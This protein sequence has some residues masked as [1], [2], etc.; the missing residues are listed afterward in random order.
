M[1]YRTISPPRSNSS[2]NYW[3]SIGYSGLAKAQGSNASCL[4]L[5]P[6]VPVSGHA[7]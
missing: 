7:S 6:V 4:K 1:G 5:R 3:N 2:D